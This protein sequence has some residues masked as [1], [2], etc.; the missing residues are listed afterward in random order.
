MTAYPNELVEM[1]LA[2]VVASKTEAPYRRGDM[3]E[4]RRRRASPWVIPSPKKGGSRP[5]SFRPAG[6]FLF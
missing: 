1:V 4:R 5:H 3:F 6:V 2:H